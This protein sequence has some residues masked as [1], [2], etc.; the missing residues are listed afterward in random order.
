[1]HSGLPFPTR[2]KAYYFFRP[3]FPPASLS[4]VTLHSPTSVDTISASV[5]PLISSASRGVPPVPLAVAVQRCRAA[6]PAFP[7]FREPGVTLTRYLQEAKMTGYGAS[8]G[9][10]WVKRSVAKG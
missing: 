10:A 9:R 8:M 6:C 4:P 1:M 3:F 5:M 7:F 2:A